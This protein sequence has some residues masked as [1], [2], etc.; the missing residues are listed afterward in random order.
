MKTYVHYR[1]RCDS[2]EYRINKDFVDK[3]LF[4]RLTERFDMRDGN[5]EQLVFK[6]FGLVT[7]RMCLAYK[8]IEQHRLCGD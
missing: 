7:C 5:Q 6:I 1:K 2:F 4:I 3:K 8:E